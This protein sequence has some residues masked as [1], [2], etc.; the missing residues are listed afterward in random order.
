MPFFIVVDG[1]SSGETK[2]CKSNAVFSKL[3]CVLRAEL[4]KAELVIK[5][6]I[7]GCLLTRKCDRVSFDLK[8]LL[9]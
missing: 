7:F 4:K 1:K 8:N 5:L 9:W 3:Q 6:I 2:S